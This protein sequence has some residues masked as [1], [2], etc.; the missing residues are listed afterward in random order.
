MKTVTNLN[1]NYKP[2]YRTDQST[3]DTVLQPSFFI[4]TKPILGCVLSTLTM[5]GS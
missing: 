2:H 1:K 4:K 5:T 3:V